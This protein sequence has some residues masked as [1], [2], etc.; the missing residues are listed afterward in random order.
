MNY[1]HLQ[2][3]KCVIRGGTYLLKE[4][5]I[6]LIKEKR[7][8]SYWDF[9]QEYHT[10]KVK[11]LHD[12]LC[13]ANNIENKEAYLIFGVADDGRIIGGTED[14][15]R[16]NQEFF[17]SFLQG[18]KFAGNM[19]PH[20]ILRTIVIKK[21]EIDIL[22]IKQSQN[23]PFYLSEDFK[24]GKERVYQGNIYTRIEDR[25]TP[26]N[27]TADP[28]RIEQLWKIRLGLIPIPIERFKNYLLQKEQWSE[29]SKG[30]YFLEAPEFTVVKNEEETQGMERYAAP[31]YAYNQ[32]NTHFSY[33]FYECK[34][35]ETVL[36]ESQ[37]VALDSGR[38]HTPTPEWS[39]IPI[40]ENRQNN[41]G[42]RYFIKNTML[43]NLHIFMFE[44]NQEEAVSAHREFMDLVCV[45]ETELEKVDFEN[46]IRIEKERILSVRDENI[47][48]DSLE[49]HKELNEREQ[50]KFMI[51]IQTGNLLV[52][53]L[54]RFRQLK[55]M[56]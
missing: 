1:S 24:V 54:E 19:T 30:N 21:Q 26:I 39:Y 15:N 16:Q 56:R 3:S 40:D 44:A 4:R 46:Y 8:G 9:K 18:K 51:D 27:E 36:F 32:M 17:I 23:I 35:F 49:D 13:L 33:Y 25:N 22:V 28:L 43:Y 41:M 31:F 52:K 14:K 5:I 53:E 20:V 37:T 34:Y 29:N 38:Y 42:Y 48:N 2:I 47:K 50:D 7:E 11:L 45:F 6:E 55:G 12:I 10:N